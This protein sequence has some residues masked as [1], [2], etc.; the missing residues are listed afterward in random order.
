M[1]ENIGDNL[2]KAGREIFEILDEILIK[3]LESAERIVHKIW[4]KFRGKL[5]RLKTIFPA[6][7]V[8]KN[9]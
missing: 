2:E 3:I 1:F 4:E 8:R 5:T 6:L 7:Y 9:S